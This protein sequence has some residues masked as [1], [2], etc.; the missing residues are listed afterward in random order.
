MAKFNI[1]ANR[2]FTPIREWAWIITLV[3]AFGGLWFPKLGYIVMGVMVG[4]TVTAFVKGRYWCGNICPHGS[5][6]DKVLFPISRNVKIPKIL[7]SKTV[8]IIFFSWFMYRFGSK[9]IKVFGLW[10]KTTF[11]DKLGYVFAMNYLM[12]VI[13]GVP[14]AI[15]ISPRAWCSFCPMG[16]LQKMSYKLGQWLGINKKTDVKVTAAATEMCHTCGKCSRVCPMQLDPYQEFDEETNQVD[17]INCIRCATC[18]ENCPAGI[19]TIDKEEDARKIKTETDITGYEDRQKIIARIDKIK[20]LRDGIRE[21]TFKFERP[22]KVD[23]KAG[24][25]ILVKIQDEPEM[26]RAYSISSYNEDSRTISVTIQK[27]E[28]GY[29]TEKIF[30]NFKVG[31]RVELEGPMG[32]ELLVDKDAKEV[33]LV[34]GGIG[35]TPFVPIVRDLVENDNNIEKVTLIYGVNYQNEF[36]YDDHF[37]KFDYKS[38]KFDYVKVCAFD[39]EWEGEKGFVTDVMKKMETLG[40]SKIYMCGPKP[41]IDA[42]LQTFKELDVKEENTFYESA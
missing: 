29:G 27:V 16:T 6:Y 15:L 30:E 4:L 7:K 13:L 11:V 25:F 24:Q 1:R 40:E 36:L 5:L 8:Q 34:G 12:V 18:V 20:T 28:D 22:H 10:G 21:F 35:I 31:D 37:K 23:Y 32:H 3:V 38:D 26:Y 17:N 33:V 9:L 42:S 2:I 39:E 14:L 19:L 41:M